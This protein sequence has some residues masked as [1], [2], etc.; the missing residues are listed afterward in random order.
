M[1][2]AA[3]SARARIRSWF[4]CLALYAVRLRNRIALHLLH[5]GLG[6]NNPLVLDDFGPHYAGWQ[7]GQQRKTRG[8]CLFLELGFCSDELPSFDRLDLDSV[9]GLLDNAYLV[10]ARA[11]T[12]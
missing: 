6:S 2:L 8:F 4:D 11:I 3:I 12:S 7:L 10:R 1:V 9:L 5:G